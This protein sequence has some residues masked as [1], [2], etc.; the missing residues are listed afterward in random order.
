M[1]R[2]FAIEIDSWV[3]RDLGEHNDFDGANEAAEDL[4]GGEIGFWIIDVE[5]LKELGANIKTVI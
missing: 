3:V 1:K 5:G 2:Y 4:I